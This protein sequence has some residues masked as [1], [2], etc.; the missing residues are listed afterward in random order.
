MFILQDFIRLMNIEHNVIHAQT[1][2]LTQADTLIQPQ[3]SGNCMNW[4][5]GHLLE[6]QVTV[7]NLL[8]V[9]PPVFNQDL[10]IYQR[11][12]ERLTADGPGVLT[13]ERLLE[14]L[15]AAHRALIARLATMSDA[16]FAAEIPFRD[17]KVTLGWRIFFLHFHYTYHLGQL[18]LLRQLAGKT[19]PVI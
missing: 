7:L 4:V 8:D 6:N 15:D 3:P 1:D 5:L 17:R 19:D 13:L 9:E 18:E 14:L 16:N 11:E 10:A 2:G 12:S